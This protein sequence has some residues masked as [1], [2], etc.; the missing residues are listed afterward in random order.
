M[1]VSLWGLT[2]KFMP[3]FSVALKRV[4][5]LLLC[6]GY[7]PEVAS[8]NLQTIWWGTPTLP[9]SPEDLGLLL[10]IRKPGVA[11]LLAYHWV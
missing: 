9:A 5:S 7:W 6:H 4:P 2:L 11:P 10:S 8:F 1:P 3:N